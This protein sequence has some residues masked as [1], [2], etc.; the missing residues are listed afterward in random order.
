M[1]KIK[2]IIIA[3]LLLMTNLGF[4]VSIA[5]EIIKQLRESGQL[6][7]IAQ[8]DREARAKGVWEANPNPVRRGLATSVDTLHCLIILVDFSDMQHESGIHSNPGSFDTLLFS[9]EIRHPGSMTDYY[10]ETS[11]GQVLLIGTVTQWYRMPQPYSYYV[12]GQRGF[13]NYPHNAQRLTEDAAT[14][15]DPDVDFTIYDNNEDG[16]VDAL[17]II[18]AGP[19]YEDTGN[20]NYIHSHAWSL[21]YPIVFDNA[22][23]SRYSMEPEETASRALITIG[24]F[25]HEFGHVLGL[26]DLY[27]YDYDSDGAGMW[28]LM[29]AGSWGGGG[30]TPVHFDVWSR[31]KLGWIAPTI[32]EQNLVHEQ[33]DAI[34]YSPDAY[35]LYSE[36]VPS[37]QYFMVENRRRRLFDI[38][39]PGEGLLIYHIDESVPNNDDQTHYKVAV[40]QADGRFDLENNRGAD[41]GDP[42]P[43]T[44]N[45]RTFDDFSV[46]NTYL[47]NGQPS[48]VSL[49]NISNQDSIMYADMSIM[50]IDPFFQVLTLTFNDSSG[51]NNGR[52]DTGETCELLFTAKNIR[53]G[54]DNFTV[55]ARC[56][57]PSVI[58][59]DSTATF[60]SIPVNHQFDNYS[61][62]MVFSVPGNFQTNFVNITLEFRARDGQYNQQFQQRCIFGTPQIL[63]VD[64]DGGGTI[65]TFYTSAL[66]NYIQLPYARWDIASQGSPV[67]ELSLHPYVIWFTGD[68]RPEAIPPAYVDGIINYLAAG[69]KLFITSQDFVQLIHER[70]NPQDIVLLRDYLKLDYDTLSTSYVE[71]GIAGTI[72]AGMRYVSSGVGGASNQFSEDSYICLPGGTSL[73]N[74]YVS[75]K[76]VAVGVQSNYAAISIGFGIEAINN[77]HPLSRSRAVFMQTA[78]TYLG[79][80]TNIDDDQ[81][82]L[83]QGIGLAQNY[84]NPFNPTTTISYALAKAGD[85][86]LDI[87][88]ILGRLVA[89][90]IKTYQQAGQHRFV[91]TASGLASGMYLYRLTCG[92]EIQCRR[93]TYL[94]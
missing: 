42:W 64:D 89:T 21:P 7:S 40:E 31:M 74:Y 80:A 48:Q 29:A 14:A 72:F 36:G 94:K 69:G 55:T 20:L 63:L 18:H 46:P 71:D 45:R 41:S 15:A 68:I 85:V 93:M 60:G 39:L 17:F 16:Y 25:C 82:A 87:Y 23:V 51:N 37:R 10:T 6:E 4:G 76:I 59:S 73:L 33:I 22:Y 53:I 56:S 84:P 52:P 35:I 79:L 2:L 57:D 77:L 62:P 88:D 13:G 28:T 19:G 11:Y 83:P 58:F 27:D 44:S 38:S 43:G 67:A 30:R 3:V 1:M 91:W 65:D 9:Q 47:Y 24:V 49:T 86:R 81:S 75:N 12:D 90:P 34:E 92:N 26:P 5:P 54:V 78:L 32:L 66:D 61:D 8:A 50:G 70:G